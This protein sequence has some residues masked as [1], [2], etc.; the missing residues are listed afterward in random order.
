MKFRGRT[1]RHLFAVRMQDDSFPQRRTEDPLLPDSDRRLLGI[2]EIGDGRDEE[3]L[4]FQLLFDGTGRSH[5]S[6]SSS[7]GFGKVLRPSQLLKNFVIENGRERSGVAE[8]LQFSVASC[9]FPSCR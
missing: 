2:R 9:R 7:D 6:F 4:L 8:E 3:R 5:F 1:F